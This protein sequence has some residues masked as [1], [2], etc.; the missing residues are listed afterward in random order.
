MSFRHRQFLKAAPHLP[1]P[2]G[3]A[4]G[5]QQPKVRKSTLHTQQEAFLL[6]H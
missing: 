2:K 1:A 5:L 3:T 6:R 4:E